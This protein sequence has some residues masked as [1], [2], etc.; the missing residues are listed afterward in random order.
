MPS[1]SQEKYGRFV[2]DYMKE[3]CP[4]GSSKAKMRGGLAAASRA[5]KAKFLEEATAVTAERETAEREH[6]D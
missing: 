5:Y 1:A 6:L 2:R 4:L 3:R